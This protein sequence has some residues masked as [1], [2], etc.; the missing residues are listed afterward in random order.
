MSQAAQHLVGTH[1]FSAY[2]AAGCQSKTPVRRLDKIDVWRKDDL[3]FIEIEANAFL[4]HMV[5]NIAGVLLAVGSG[6]KETDW[7]KTV[8]ESGD[9]TVA[10]VTAPPHGLYLLDVDYSPDFD[11]PRVSQTQLVW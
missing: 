9:R 10:G 11:L 4:H 1:D 6:E 7:S 5:R 3:V 8:L 2:R